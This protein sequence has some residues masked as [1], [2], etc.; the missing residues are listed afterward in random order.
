MS[1]QMR[2]EIAQMRIRHKAV[3][4]AV[5]LFEETNSQEDLVE[6]N[7]ALNL[8]LTATTKKDILKAIM[9]MH[10]IANKAN[11]DIHL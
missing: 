11:I 10:K 3:R 2:R 8:A 1:N 4:I 9:K 7:L 5:R 6:V